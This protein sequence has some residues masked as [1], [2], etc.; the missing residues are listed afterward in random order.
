MEGAGPSQGE[1]ADRVAKVAEGTSA[2]ELLR[3]LAATAERQAE[4]VAQLRAQH[5]GESSV[6]AEKDAEIG[7]LRAQLGEALA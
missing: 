1:S 5:V 6:V 7:R 3:E 2:Q 4:L